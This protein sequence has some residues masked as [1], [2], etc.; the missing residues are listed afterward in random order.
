MFIPTRSM[1]NQMV[2]SLAVEGGQEGRHTT[3]H[4]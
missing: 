4:T 3:R 1:Y 2:F